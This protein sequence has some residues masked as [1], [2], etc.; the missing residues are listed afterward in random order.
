MAKL[1]HPRYGTVSE[2]SFPAAA[3]AD[4]QLPILETFKK[5]EVIHDFRLDGGKL[6][7]WRPW[8]EADA[9]DVSFRSMS[10]TDRILYSRTIF[11]RLL[12]LL[13]SLATGH[14]APHPGNIFLVDDRDLVLVDAV[15]NNVVHAHESIDDA[16]LVWL[17]GRR[18]PRGWSLRDWDRVSLVRVSTL[19][20]QH[21]STWEERLSNQDMAA[22]CR[23]WVEEAVGACGPGSDDAQ[24]LKDALPLLDRIGDEKPRPPEEILEEDLAKLERAKPGLRVLLEQDEEQLRA[25][26]ETVGSSH[27]QIDAQIGGWLAFHR[28]RR[29][30]EL[31]ALA[32]EL[33]RLGLWGASR[34]LVA[35]RS[36]IAA[37]RV[38]THHGIDR[39]EAGA[40]VWLL[41][42]ENHWIDEREAARHCHTFYDEL[43]KAGTV[44]MKT[45]AAH[46]TAKLE[47]PPDVAERLAELELERQLLGLYS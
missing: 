36:C 22:L 45:L 4:D 25:H 13:Q 11:K 3:L 44:T 33:L 6:T 27:G 40:R 16:T 21:P 10:V 46:V 28:I 39:A 7:L 14:G 9:I 37:E 42:S 18:V 17:W 29:E 41:L 32:E 1:E 8:L 47:Y 23:Q 34:K 30:S 5:T 12:A 2:R 15:F 38:F 35:A 31:R 20:A 24:P 26:A 19:L 43:L